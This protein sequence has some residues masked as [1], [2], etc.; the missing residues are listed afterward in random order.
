MTFTLPGY[1]LRKLGAYIHQKPEKAPAQKDNAPIIVHNLHS[2]KPKSRV[3][4]KTELR[5][6]KT[7]K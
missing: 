5:K 3:K 7:K 2:L 1:A 6:R 4:P